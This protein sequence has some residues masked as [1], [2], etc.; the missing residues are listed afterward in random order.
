MKKGI[1]PIIAV[2]ILLLITV[3]LAGMAW[4]FLQ[5]YFTTLTGKNAQVSDSFCLSGNSRIVITN[6]GTQT[7]D[8]S[9]GAISGASLICGDVTISKTAG[10]NFN[11]GA[12]FIGTPTPTT[13]LAKASATFNETCGPPGTT[14]TYRIV[15]GTS[16]VS[17]NIATLSC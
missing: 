17:P 10:G 7:L 9:C 4:A 15:A 1:T 3:A 12:G 6:I 2:I 13:I 8:I 11:T 16:G 14:C 5:G